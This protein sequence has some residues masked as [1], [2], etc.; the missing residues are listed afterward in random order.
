M[1]IKRPKPKAKITPKTKDLT[2]AARAVVDS[3]P[4]SQHLTAPERDYAARVLLGQQNPK[5]LEERPLLKETIIACLVELGVN[6][7]Y[8]A[9]H[10]KGG[11]EARRSYGKEGIGAPDWNSRHKYFETLMDMAGMKEEPRSPLV[12]N[13]H[14][15]YKSNLRA[16]PKTIDVSAPPTLK[17]QRRL[18]A[19]KPTNRRGI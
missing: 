7:N 8:L 9:E 11:L 12:G 17:A 3:T 4:Q 10:V 6:T 5:D 1:A 16:E 13:L 15:H 2:L 18:Q 14:L 19:A